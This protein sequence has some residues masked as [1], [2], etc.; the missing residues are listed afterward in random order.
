MTSDPSSNADAR[1]APESE[2]EEEL[3]FSFASRVPSEEI[4]LV[5][6]RNSSPLK[7]PHFAN[8]EFSVNNGEDSQTSLLTN[9]DEFEKFVGQVDRHPLIFDTT[10]ETKGQETAIGIASQVFFPFLVAGVGMV[11]AGLL[12]DVVQVCGQDRLP[13]FTLRACI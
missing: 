3:M 10:F 5:S 4:R 9:S 1:D 6:R 2:D 8:N 12:L 13:V 11:C 7:Q